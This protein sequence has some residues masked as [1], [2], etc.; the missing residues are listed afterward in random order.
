MLFSL[1][2]MIFNNQAFIIIY[3][4]YFYYYSLDMGRTSWCIAWWKAIPAAYGLTYTRGVAGLLRS[5]L[6]KK[7]ILLRNILYTHRLKGFFNNEELSFSKICLGQIIYIAFLIHICIWAS[8][9]YESQTDF[10]P[11]D[12]KLEQNQKIVD[13]ILTA[14]ADNATM[15]KA[16]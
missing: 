16:Y 6:I 4:I 5:A 12:V 7:R 9:G 13:T 3:I 2:A 14:Y 11:L 10:T 15:Q 1:N 8:V